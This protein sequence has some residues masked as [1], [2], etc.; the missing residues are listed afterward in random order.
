MSTLEYV[1]P[2]WMSGGRCA[3]VDPELFFAE[4]AGDK[5]S[6]HAKKICATCDV[7]DACL[8]YALR[9]RPIEDFGVWG[10][11]TEFERRAIRLARGLR[12]SDVIDLDLRDFVAEATSV[13]SDESSDFF[14]D[15]AAEEAELEALIVSTLAAA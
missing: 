4:Y 1:R 11:T 14:V 3:E 7:K 2:V 10:G 12:S 13:Q 15:E 5:H 8:E 9:M 6:T